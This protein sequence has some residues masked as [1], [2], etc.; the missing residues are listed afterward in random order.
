[1]AKDLRVN[2]RIRAREVRLIDENGVQVGIIPFREALDMA[3][4]RGL[5]VIEVS[6]TANPP[7]CRIMDYGKYKYE[8]GK[9]EREAQKK[10][11][12]TEVKG[13][14]M[15]PGTDEHD[16]QFKLRN[17]LKFLK[18]GHKVKVTVIFRSREFTHPE[19]ARESLNR[20]AEIAKEENVATVEKSA[21]MEGRTMTMILAPITEK[22]K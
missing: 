19:F 2:E 21:S 17:A 12:M 18:E 6:P 11:R 15:R 5:D 9:R 7:V 10:Q 1:M 8:L 16:F 3:K 4:Q 14:R 22:E 20:M 13:I